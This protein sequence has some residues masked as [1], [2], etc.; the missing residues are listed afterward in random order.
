MS[1]QVPNSGFRPDR[2]DPRIV[3]P[4]GPRFRVIEEEENE[5]LFNGRNLSSI[6][7]IGLV[8]GAAAIGGAIGGMLW[9]KKASVAEAKEAPAP[10]AAA[11]APAPLAATPA[12]APASVPATVTLQAPVGSTSASRS[13]ALSVAVPTP[14]PAPAVISNPYTI[15]SRNN[16]IDPNVFNRLPKV[17]KLPKVTKLVTRLGPSIFAAP[18]LPIPKPANS[19]TAQTGLSQPIPK[20]QT[21]TSTVQTP[22]ATAAAKIVATQ[23]TPVKPLAPVAALP[24]APKPAPA[25]APD[26]PSLLSFLRTPFTHPAK[27]LAAPSAS[28]T[29]AVVERETK[30]RDEK[31]RGTKLNKVGGFM[32]PSTTCYMAGVF[33]ALFAIPG[34]YENYL[35]KAFPLK[36]EK[37]E[38]D[39]DFAT[40][41]E[42][43]K[44]IR[45]SLSGLYILSK[46]GIT[47][48][49]TVMDKTR[50]T[51][52]Q[53]GWGL[54]RGSIQQDGQ[55][56]CQFLFTVLGVP[57]FNTYKYFKITNQEG[58][59]VDGLGDRIV[60]EGLML[61]IDPPNP[62]SKE[63]TSSLA[64]LLKDEVFE[65]E[66]THTV[67]ALTFCLQDFRM[68]KTAL[69]MVLPVQLTRFSNLNGVPIKNRIPVE[70]SKTLE[71]PLEDEPGRSV[72]YKLC[73]CLIHSGD[74]ARIGHYYTYGEETI[75][76][77][78]QWVKLDDGDVSIF[79]KVEAETDI[80]TNGYLFFYIPDGIV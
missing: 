72:R 54:G 17:P 31:V 64:K 42:S 51:H 20:Q 13:P 3:A 76:E 71:F 14:T 22:A 35:V 49:K 53:N 26:R 15:P 57:S 52:C 40:R 43:Q 34:F 10:L 65:R 16:H 55:E 47:I 24:A 46:K 7:G 27:E 12:P 30:E 58:I 80:K 28:G 36:Q 68:R 6:L 69:P 38:V 62:K 73:S 75:V 29:T 21:P 1:S 39:T 48:S 33:Q 79:D 4:S 60:N 37:G 11:P 77:Q 5:S 25:V 66:K 67:P 70:I 78:L 41:L 32:N 9:Q 2:P 50:E 45:A 63:K 59:Q 74:E 18:S 44:K 8:A 19:T 61:A 23:L 56:Y